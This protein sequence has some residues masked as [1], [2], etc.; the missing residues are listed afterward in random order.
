[1]TSLGFEA[2]SGSIFQMLS[3]MDADGSGA[4]DFGEWLSL[5]TKRVNDKDSRANINKIFALF[6]DGKF[7]VVSGERRLRAAKIIGLTKV[8]CIILDSEKDSDEIALVENI[9]RSDLHPVE[10]A[11]SIKKIVD[12]RGWGSQTELTQK[13]GLSSSQLSEL[14]KITDLSLDV[15]QRALE[16]NFR[17]RENFRKLFSLKSDEDKMN[18]IENDTSTSENSRIIKNISVLRISFSSNEINIQ[19]NALSKLTSDQKKVVRS[20]LEDILRELS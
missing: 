20:K 5:M 19:K 4:I 10:L 2:K 7:E 1:M 14:I 11:R 18:F 8:P 6:D 16:K 13:I 17:G 3:D 9:Q 12:S 15:Q